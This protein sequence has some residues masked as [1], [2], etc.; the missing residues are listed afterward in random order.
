MPVVADRLVAILLKSLVY[1]TFLKVKV[2]YAS[3][4]YLIHETA[5]PENL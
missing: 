1:F 5:T 2:C 3:S 4:F